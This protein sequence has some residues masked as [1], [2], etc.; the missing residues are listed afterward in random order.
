MW[1]VISAGLAVIYGG[2][3]RA[4]PVLGRDDQVLLRPLQQSHSVAD[5]LALWRAGQVRDLQ[6]LRDLSF[7]LD[8]AIGRATGWHTFHLTNV[9]LFVAILALAWVLLVQRF[10]KTWLTR[11]ALVGF[12]FH[13]IFVGSVGWISARK[14]LLACVLILGATALAAPDLPE[15]KARR[16]WASVALYV[17]SLLAQ[18]IAV[19]WPVW[20]AAV[21]WRPGQ[22]KAQLFAQT[23]VSLLVGAA[24]SWANL[25][26]YAGAFVAQTHS[27]KFVE[28][29]GLGPTVSLLALGRDFFNC[30]CPIALAT[31]Y[32]PERIF[33]LIGLLLLPLFGWLMA[34]L[35]G[36]RTAATWLGFFLFPLAIVTVKM[37]NIFV[38]D[39]YLL[40]PM[41]GLLT[42]VVAA[43]QRV[44]EAA[45]TAAA[46]GGGAVVL[47][48]ASLSV[49]LAPSWSSDAA[50]WEHAY[51][52]ERTPNV[53]AKEAFYRANAG[54]FDA[55]LDA[56]LQL[57]DWQPRHPEAA[58][59]FARAVYLD[60]RHTPQEKLAA[61]DAHPFD[62]PWY[63]YFRANLF[64]GLG[65][66]G[67]AMDALRRAAPEA[68]KLKDQAAV[69][70][71]D[72]AVLCARA[73][74]QDCAQLVRTFQRAG[75]PTWNEAAF[76]SRIA[77]AGVSDPR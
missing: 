15:R 4:D 8:V 54:D 72:A 16:G 56:A 21:A 13:P 57:L 12:A 40:T 9:M 39:T 3:I 47:G 43:L 60:P 76:R 19:L 14:H 41:V 2:L 69:I 53:L 75:G 71:G 29:E 7:A 20:R 65:D 48:L 45:R 52:T 25:Q 66:R 28:A 1:L 62:D 18:P 32:A 33:N 31:S 24:V 10:G 6:P 30:I 49:A 26:Y 55:A 37:T 50:L 35:V 23:A 67:A 46:V 63:H 68:A 51:Q 58:F 34:R 22:R 44:P 42:L 17:L 11:G 70:A 59:V 73:G 27:S 64:A 5:Y 77:A 36:L 61:L 38:S 74:A